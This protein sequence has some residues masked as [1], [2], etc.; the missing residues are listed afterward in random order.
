VPKGLLFWMLMILWLVFGLGSAW[1]EGPY[2]RHI[3]TGSAL[4]IF[5]LFF[6]VGWAL[7]G[8]VIQ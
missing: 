8:F 2:R 3:L 6:I 4:L 5:I 7:F 1:Y